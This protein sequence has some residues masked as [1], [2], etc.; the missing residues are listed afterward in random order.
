MTIYFGL[1]ARRAVYLDNYAQLPE[2]VV[3]TLCR[4]RQQGFLKFDS[5]DCE[6]R[7]VIKVTPRLEGEAP[8]ALDLPDQ[9]RA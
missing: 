3:D 9:W 4:L 2:H 7:H 6:G 5:L 8:G 1:Q